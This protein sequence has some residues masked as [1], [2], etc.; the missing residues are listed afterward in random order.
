VGVTEFRILGPIEAVREGRVLPL[1]GAKQRATLALLLIAANERVAADRLIEDLWNGHA[2]RG[3]HK[4]LQMHVLRLRQALGEPDDARSD[5]VLETLGS[6]YRLTV[7]PGALD[8][9]RFESASAEG[10]SL[11]AAGEP[12]P[13][14]DRLRAALAEWRGPA[15]GEVGD[16]PF[17]RLEV[18]RL[19]EL[20]VTILE[21]CIQADLAMGRHRELIAELESLTGAEVFRERLWSQ[22]MLALYR[23]SRQADALATYRRVRAQLVEELGIEPGAELQRLHESILA[24]DARLDWNPPA[25]VSTPTMRRRVTDSSAP[26]RHNLPALRSS[27]VDRE[28]ESSS[29]EDGLRSSRVVTLTGVGGVGKTRLAL[30][31]AERTLGWWPGGVWLVEL[32]AV[33]EAS[34]VAET[35][36]SRLGLSTST[37]Q[38][39]VTAIAHRLDQRHLL[40][41]LDNCEHVLDAC[42]TLAAAIARG[43]SP[44]RLLATSR[45][46]LAVAGEHVISV[47]PLPTPSDVTGGSEPA[48]AHAVTLFLDRAR[49]ARPRFTARPGELETIGELCRALDGLPL[50]IELAASRVRGMS[51]VEILSRL[52]DRLS[53]GSY[54]RDREPRHRDLEATIAWSYD[55][56]DDRQR[57][58]FRR[59]AVFSS[60]FT[61]AA[62]EQVVGDEDVADAILSLV[63]HSM[64]AVAGDVEPTRY[65]MLETVREFGLR[66]LARTGEA[67]DTNAAYLDWAVGFVELSIQVVETPGR[68]ERLREVEAEY[69]NLVNAVA[70]N[71]PVDKRLRLASGLAELLSAGTSVVREIRRLLDEVLVAAGELNSTEVRRSRLMLARCLRKLGELDEARAHLATTAT[72][73]AAADDRPLGAAIAAEQ[74][75]V[76][77]KAHRQADAMRFLDQCDGLGARSD[78]RVWSY[79]MLVEGQMRYDLLGELTEARQ[80]YERCIEQA[81]EHGPTEHLIIALAV[82]AEVAVELDDLATADRCAR[83]VLAITDPVADAY[84]RGGAM[85][86]LGRAALRG[87]Q[88]SEASSWLAEG[89]RLDIERGSMEAPEMLESLAQAVAESGSATVSAALLGAAAALR[90]RLGIGRSEREQACVDAALAAI[91]QRLTEPDLTRALAPARELTERGLL[92]LIDRARRPVVTMAAVGGRP[93]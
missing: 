24:H 49:S 34:A 43:R 86:A 32:A 26:P 48:A 40:L 77:I 55:L 67:V 35:V 62:A 66:R 37:E 16:Q 17:A 63:D 92:A 51:P 21:D 46:P 50:A 93:S 45:T 12:G 18:V 87:S 30:E 61:L 90:E 28:L 10:R 69:R 25:G 57:R 29:M 58:A 91:R 6:G 75:L 56:L 54:E 14:A 73:A 3:A 13:A 83:E 71:G 64:L 79:R 47:T 20:R 78:G 81:R 7:E 1:G 59:V 89:A 33:T 72:H 65:R 68:T 8:R 5:S 38:D 23:S 31:V 15:F 70:V 41:I 11:L 74:A 27:F 36:A 85:F 80:L 60:P 19:E 4:S 52:G 44:S 9:E 53:L 84:S 88:P 42:A 39:P 76:E 22:L 2:P 82:L